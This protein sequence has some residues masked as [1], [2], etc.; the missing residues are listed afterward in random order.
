MYELKREF[1][2][3]LSGLKDLLRHKCHVLLR[4]LSTEACR[5][6]VPH[7]QRRTLQ[8][9]LETEC[10]L[11]TMRVCVTRFHARFAP[12]AVQNE[13]DEPDERDI[14]AHT[15][16]ASGIFSQWMRFFS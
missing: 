7:I 6:E 5:R 9:T 1:S 3:Y 15:W 10:T 4:I 11:S 2:G 12:K 8:L 14:K 16:S 13:N